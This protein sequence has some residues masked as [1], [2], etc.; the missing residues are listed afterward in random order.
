VELFFKDSLLLFLFLVGS[1]FCLVYGRTGLVIGLDCSIAFGVIGFHLGLDHLGWGWHLSR[2]ILGDIRSQ[3][4]LNSSF[5]LSFSR[6]GHDLLGLIFGNCSIAGVIGGL[7]FNYSLM[8]RVFEIDNILF[9]SLDILVHLF[10]LFFI[11]QLLLLN[12]LLISFLF[13]LLGL[14]FLL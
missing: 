2:N 4:G 9:S 12:L 10:L 14:L 1:F 7:V 5:N 3:I 6:G 13:I 8:H 11:I